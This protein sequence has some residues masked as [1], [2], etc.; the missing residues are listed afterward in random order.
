MTAAEPET[1]QVFHEYLLQLSQRRIEDDPRVRA[2]HAAKRAM[3]ML[4][5]G[6]AFLYFY[7]LDRMVEAL[8][9]L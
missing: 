5:V 3:W 2:L 4:L 1:Q 8:S 7:L 6:C 9:L